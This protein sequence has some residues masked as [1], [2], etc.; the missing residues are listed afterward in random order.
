MR[1]P[2]SIAAAVLAL[3]IMPATVSAQS[4]RTGQEGRAQAEVQT[5]ADAG[6]KTAEFEL[7]RR[8]YYSRELKDDGKAIHWFELA[9][10]QG[11]PWAEYET[12]T[13][14]VSGEGVAADPVKAM[15]WYRAAARDGV[16][17]ANYDIGLMYLTGEG[18][19]KDPVEAAKWLKTAADGKEP[20]GELFLG[21]MYRDGNGVP[22]DYPQAQTLLRAAA[23]Q[24]VAPAAYAL[25]DMIRQGKGV[26][27]NMVLGQAWRMVGMQLDALKAGDKRPLVYVASPGLTEIQNVDAAGT[28]LRLMK[29]LGISK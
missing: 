17:V 9:A 8:Y 26:P 13:M 29:E 21:L 20:R 18:V 7:G 27:A 28:Y 23:A 16:L 4:Y 22:Q 25:G 2:T 1:N 15:V 19:P 11:V 24:R 12:A 6:D 5:A 3:A 10:Q 14:Y